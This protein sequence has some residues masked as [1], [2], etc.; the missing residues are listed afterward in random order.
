MLFKL[1]KLKLASFFISWRATS[2]L[3]WSRV[4]PLSSQ[5]L[6][7]ERTCSISSYPH[8]YKKAPSLLLSHTLKPAHRALTV[9]L[10][11]FFRLVFW[12]NLSLLWFAR[13]VCLC[14][15]ENSC[16]FFCFGFLFPAV[17]QLF[18]CDFQLLF[19]LVVYISYYIKLLSHYFF[20][21]TIIIY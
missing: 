10:S 11:S 20:F 21:L 3:A 19:Y 8:E 16:P 6:T 2:P 15:T 18:I 14:L 4:S 12:S 17:F 5:N 9:F 7:I 13:I 1:I